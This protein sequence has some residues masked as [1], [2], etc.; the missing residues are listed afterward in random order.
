[1]SEAL[2]TQEVGSLAKPAWRVQPLK[3][4]PITDAHIEEAEIWAERLGI[5]PEESTDLLRDW[6]GEAVPLDPEI[7]AGIKLLAVRYAIRLQEV[8]GLDILYDGEQSRPEMYEDLVRKAQG[9]KPRGRLRA[10]DNRSF[11]KFALVDEPGIETPGYNEEFAQV[12]AETDRRIKVPITGAYTVADWSFD[13]FYRQSLEQGGRSLAAPDAKRA[14]VLDVAERVVRPNIAALVEAGAEWVQI[15]EPAATTTPGEVPLFVEAFNRSTAGLPG[16]FSVHICFSDYSH[17]F[18]YIEEM[19]NC[20]Q[21]S[22]EFANRDG[23][24]LGTDAA[25]R[26]AYEVLTD[27]HQHAPDAAIGLGV[28][29]IHVDELEVPELVRDRTLRA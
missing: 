12:Q 2:L 22:L 27:F 15:D 20:S 23:S 28:T 29:N 16:K 1:M 21:F 5:A 14:F 18:P 10:F 24:G 8:A 17:L 13:E 26:P 4:Q 19:E 3:G 7:Q 25:A 6:Q 9:F 11:L